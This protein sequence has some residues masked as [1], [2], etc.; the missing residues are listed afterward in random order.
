[1][2]NVSEN[3]RKHIIF[4]DSSSESDKDTNNSDDCC[5]NSS[6]AIKKTRTFFSKI[7]K[8]T[9]APSSSIS[10]SSSTSS[11]S[12][13][14]TTTTNVTNE[15]TILDFILVKN[16][17]QKETSFGF[18]L[19]G[20]ETTKGKHFIDQVEPKLAGARAGL[21]P[22]DKI[23][24][25]NGVWVDNYYISQLIQQI[26]Y[27]TGLNE[28]KLHLSVQRETPITAATN[29]RMGATGSG[30]QRGEDGQ[31]DDIDDDSYYANNHAIKQ[32]LCMFFRLVV[33]EFFCLFVCFVYR[34]LLLVFNCKE[35]RKE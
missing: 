12:L 34:A 31:L 24:C 13:H 18:Q 28:I 29:T 23:V 15:A 35:R 32:T 19:R 30:M 10:T 8:T 25:V 4:T 21:R 5:T 26:E 33:F 22:R 16:K 1:M 3:K 14:N 2:S 17:A 20:D 27:E 6:N 11:S 7:A 9:Y